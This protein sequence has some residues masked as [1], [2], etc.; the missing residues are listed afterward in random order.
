M[1]FKK[2]NLEKI[3]FTV[4]LPI[5]E[6]QDII[7]GLPKALESIFKNTL[8]PDQVVVTVDGKVS[9][10]FENLIK[11]FEKKYSLDLVWINKKVGLDNALNIGLTKCRNEIIF[12]ADGDDINHNER[13]IL[14]L[15]YLLDNYD[16]VGSNI[17]EYDENGN[18]IATREVPI[19]DFDIRKMIQYRNPIN[20]MS[21]GFRKTK[22]INLG[23]YPNLF[24]KGDYGLWIKLKAANLKFF[25]INRSLVK[26]KTGKRMIKDRGGL[27]YI[28]SELFLQK[29]LLDYGLTNIFF[30]FFIFLIRALVFTLPSKLRYYFYMIFLRNDK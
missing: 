3:K 18:Y 20:H 1:D 16:V 15:P 14:Q 25:N 7:D 5:L 2:L 6:R 13:F 23:G 21:V 28:L 8:L 11:V 29:Y 26:A 30:A 10:F 27:R 4:L 22:V 17:D 12:R 19:S 24:L 9:T